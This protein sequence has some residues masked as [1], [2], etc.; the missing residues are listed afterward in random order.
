MSSETRVLSLGSGADE[1]LKRKRRTRTWKRPAGVCLASS[2][3]LDYNHVMGVAS[4][5][6]KLTRSIDLCRSRFS[7]RLP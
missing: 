4:T 3:S 6:I 2:G 1:D 7:Y 5:L